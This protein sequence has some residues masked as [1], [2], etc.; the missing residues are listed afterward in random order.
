MQQ[1]NKVTHNV[2]ILISQCQQLRCTTYLYY[3]TNTISG[4]QKSLVLH[5]AVRNPRLQRYL[6]WP[7]I[8]N[9]PQQEKS[10]I[11]NAL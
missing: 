11:T 10:R 7:Q 8:N 2:L 9:L 4:L 5:T 6:T 3:F 1:L